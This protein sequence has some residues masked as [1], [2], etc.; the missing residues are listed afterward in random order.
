MR[1]LKTGINE[2]YDNVHGSTG[3]LKEIFF[4]KFSKLETQLLGHDM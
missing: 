1:N 2:K 3:Q 4:E